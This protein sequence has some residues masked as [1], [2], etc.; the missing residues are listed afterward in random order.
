MSNYTSRGLFMATWKNIW[1]TFD[2]SQIVHHPIHCHRIE[3]ITEGFKAKCISI[4]N[5]LVARG[6]FGKMDIWK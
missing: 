6:I 5:G 2:V 1:C 4:I 3:N